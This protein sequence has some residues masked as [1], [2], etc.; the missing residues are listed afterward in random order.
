MNE[1][2]TEHPRRGLRRLLTARF[3][4]EPP[5]WFGTGRKR[6]RRRSTPE[7]PE[8]QP[9]LPRFTISTPRTPAGEDRTSVRGRLAAGERPALRLRRVLGPGH[10][11]GGRDLGMRPPE[12]RD[13]L[14]ERTFFCRRRE[15]R[16]CHGPGEAGPQ[17]AAGGLDG[18]GHHQSH[19]G[20]G[21]ALAGPTRALASL[22]R[23][24]PP[25]PVAQLW[26]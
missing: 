24:A 14:G 7:R 4:L 2:D 21:P 10:W 20:N 5:P 13:S 11:R 12:F 15:T 1:V 17:D 26:P 18:P 23:R 25:R 22:P 8:L 9:A 3:R 6:S 19:N 16:A